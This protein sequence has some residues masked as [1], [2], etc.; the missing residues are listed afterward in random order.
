VLINW[1]KEIKEIYSRQILKLTGNFH[2]T[3]RKGDLG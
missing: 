2:S 1:E 3:V